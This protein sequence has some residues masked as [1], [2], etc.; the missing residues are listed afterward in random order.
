MQNNSNHQ[1]IKYIYM[2]VKAVKH[3][4]VHGRDKY[5]L[6]LET[7]ETE[8]EK[9]VMSVGQKTYKKVTAMTE[10]KSPTEHT[11]IHGKK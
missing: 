7:G 1:F 2:K 11:K 3:Q 10:K 5:Y 8:E 6:F 9:L 4:D